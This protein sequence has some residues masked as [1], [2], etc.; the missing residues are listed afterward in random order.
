MSGDEQEPPAQEK[1][2][3]LLNSDSDNIE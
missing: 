3:E 2:D 1:M